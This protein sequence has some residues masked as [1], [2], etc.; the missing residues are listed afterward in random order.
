MEKGIVILAL[1][2][3]NYG[4]MAAVLVALIRCMNRKLPIALLTNHA[5]A[6]HLNAEERKLFTLVMELDPLY[7]TAAD[8][9][10][11]PLMPRVYLDILSPFDRTLSL[12]GDQLWIQGNDPETVF[13][14]LEGRPFTI[15][16]NGY[17]ITNEHADQNMSLWGDIHAIAAAYKIQS[18]KFYKIYAEWF[19]F[20][21]NEF[22]DAFFN[23]ARDVFIQPPRCATV[24]FAGQPIT[25]ELAF[26]IAMAT[27][28]LYP[29]KE[30]YFPTYWYYREQEK[31][32]KFPF[33]LKQDY[34]TY[35]LGGNSTPLFQENI[36]NRQAAY[37]YRK[38]GLRAPYVWKNKKDFIPER[39]KI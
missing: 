32:G 14:E 10:F 36:Y 35:S 25:E 2:H 30:P 5:G 28:S 17:T 34:F 3:P 37:A 18:R 23:T 13:D 1:G 39:E 7:Y 21:K 27:H 15:C 12:D 20:E 19:Y 8:G 31:S 26:C 16:N 4:R 38:L 29:H 6:R 9:T 24:K 11:S 33:E 22:S